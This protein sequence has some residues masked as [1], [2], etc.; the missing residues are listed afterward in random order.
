MTSSKEAIRRS[1]L[2]HCLRH[3]PTSPSPIFQSLVRI[4]H[5]AFVCACACVY[6]VCVSWRVGSGSVMEW[7]PAREDRPTDCTCDEES[8]E[9]VET[10]HKGCRFINNEKIVTITPTYFREK[11]DWRWIMSGLS[12]IRPPLWSTA[13]ISRL[14][15]QRFGFDSRKD[16]IFCVAVGLERGP[17]SPCERNEELLEIKVAAPV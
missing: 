15:N 10:Q 17:L 2:P 16:Q 1:E 13:Q 6:S 11:V 3:A 12:Q 5:E 9:A 14:L 7:S 4:P 8:G